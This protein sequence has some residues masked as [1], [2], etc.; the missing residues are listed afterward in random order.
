MCGHG[1]RPKL[2]TA[3]SYVKYLSERAFD[4]RAMFPDF[5]DYL[6]FDDVAILIK[7]V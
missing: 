5:E 1:F 2:E 4:I 6:I 3:G 7:F